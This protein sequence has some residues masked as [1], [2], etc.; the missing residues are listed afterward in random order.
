MA[1]VWL[2]A[3][4]SMVGWLIVNLDSA[5]WILVLLTVGLMTF[6]LTRRPARGGGA[7]LPVRSQR[8]PDKPNG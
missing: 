6:E 3:A 7:A 2:M 4:L 5:G 1:I 8:R